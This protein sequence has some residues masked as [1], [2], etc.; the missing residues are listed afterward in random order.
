MRGQGE[1]LLSV[2][3]FSAIG[4]TSQQHK[5]ALQIAAVSGNRRVERGELVSPEESQTKDQKNW[6]RKD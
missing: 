3:S 2:T 4:I 6:R 5:Q 1:R